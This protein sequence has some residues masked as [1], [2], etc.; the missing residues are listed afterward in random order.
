MNSAQA[1]L[2]QILLPLEDN[3]G[4]EFPETLFSEIHKLLTER[5]GGLTAYS[6]APAQGVWAQGGRKMRDDIVVVE[7]MTAELD[8][9]WW[10][11][12]RHRLEQ[13]MRQE[14]IVI[15]S[16]PIALL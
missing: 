13:A 7:V 5:F 4:R 2:V 16:Q 12:F 6:R 3:D 1:H 10:K 11:D 15:R 8:A 14:R 9:A